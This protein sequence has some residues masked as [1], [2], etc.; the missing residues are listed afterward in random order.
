MNRIQLDSERCLG[1]GQCQRVCPHGCLTL[2]DGRVQ[3]VH[4]HC[5]QC[6]HCLAA[7]PVAAIAIESLGAS[8]H[9]SSFTEL[10]GVTVPCRDDL[11]QL[12]RLMRSRRSVR[13]YH[14]RAVE[15]ALLEDLIKIGT[16]APS[17]TNSQGW[18]FTIL[19]RRADVVALGDGVAG[20][21][22][23]LNCKA[24]NPFLRGLAR[25][26]AGD[27]LGRYYRTHYKTIERGLEAW[28]DRGEDRL[29]HGAPSVI[30]VGGE[31]SASCPA[32]DALLATGQM[33]LAAYQ[34][35]LGTCLIG[36][37]VEA[38]RRDGALR[39]LAGVGCHEEVYAVIAL[40]YPDETYL[41][42]APRKEVQ[43]RLG[44]MA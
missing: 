5:L 44:Q 4:D 22:K 6:G 33:L 3:L 7:C 27:S 14:E 31:R 9:F 28:F 25:V 18:T 40:G 34:M 37:V 10:D 19:E 26:F 17:G 43:V 29:F 20:F 39:E 2:E 12:V 8:P 36:F 30:L 35:G 23:K 13:H 38:L 16:T 11:P 1:C 41:H 32:E 15:L 24:A 21:F 42:P